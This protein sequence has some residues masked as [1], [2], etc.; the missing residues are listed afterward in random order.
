MLTAAALI[1]F[2]YLLGSVPFALVIGKGIYGVD[3]REQG[4]GNIG[5]T[6][7]FRVL[8]KGAG[9]LVFACD[10]LK[11]FIPVYLALHLPAS[12]T[13]HFPTVE[14]VRLMAVLAAGAAIAGHT[15]P[16]FLKFRGGKG[17]ATGAGAILAL[18]PLLFIIT[19]AV[20]WVVLIATRTVSISSLTAVTALCIEVIVTGQPTPYTVFT[21]VG[22][23]VIF[24]AHR[25]NIRRIRKGEE[26]KVTFPWNR[27]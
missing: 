8:G 27:K 9:V 19:F 22:A 17:V 26:S 25:S 24:Y 23:A 14:N 20:F 1:V 21:F 15:F 11:G 2:A 16:I 10:V 13:S 7:V 6:N 4:S 18:M 5:A 3:V 12:L